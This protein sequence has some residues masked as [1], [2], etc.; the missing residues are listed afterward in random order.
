MKF[1]K[2]S[3]KAFRKDMLKYGFVEEI[4]DGAY[5]NIAIPSRKTRF[6]AGYD[7]VTPVEFVLK[8]HEKITI[9]TG[10]KVY[11]GPEEAEQWHLALYIRS[12]VGITRG[13]VM[14]NQ[15]GVID[16]DY[17]DN[18]DNEGDMLI[19]LRNMNDYPVTFYA[20]DRIIQGILMMHGITSDDNAEG[21]RKGGV[22]STDE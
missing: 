3:Y 22:G 8:P 12:S 9:P 18:I 4:I 7:F 20:G 11:F 14:A 15:T 17:Y 13:V 6:S 1:E 5:E 2:V 21:L 10:I 16:A 19:A